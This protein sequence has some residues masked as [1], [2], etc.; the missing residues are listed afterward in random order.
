[1]RASRTA[2]E[3]PLRDAEGSLCFKAVLHSSL[4]EYPGHIADVLFVGGCNFR[5][6][7]CH[8]LDLV[9]RPDQLPDVDDEQ[10]LAS[11]LPRRSFVDGLVITGGEPT[12]QAGL[13]P[14]LS[15]ARQAGFDIK[16]DT[17]GYQPDVLRLCLEN[18]L[19]DYVAM[20]VKTSLT[21]YPLVTG[22]AIDPARLRRSIDLIR[23]SGIDHEFRTT[24]VPGLVELADV[25]SIA[26]LIAGAQRYFLQAFR[27]GPTV[28]WGQEPPVGAPTAETVL[29]LARAAAGHG[30]R[31]VGVRG[32]PHGDDTLPAAPDRR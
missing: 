19:V 11:L 26:R 4:I 21:R 25:E 32:M 6:V 27:P 31:E 16:L 13:I 14:F 30:L 1:M 29:R 17:N 5:C 18:H 2:E 23:H 15:R 8:N 24:V 12:L 7:Y 22:V 3:A 10:L 28:G 20:D 9:L